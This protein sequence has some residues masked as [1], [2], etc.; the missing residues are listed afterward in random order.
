M[1]IAIFQIDPYSQQNHQPGTKQKF[2]SRSKLFENFVQFWGVRQ[3]GQKQAENQISDEY[4]L[5][6]DFYSSLRRAEILQMCQGGSGRFS[7]WY[8]RHTCFIHMEP[9][10]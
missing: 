6:F 2:L 8:T 3:L 1:Q 7:K 9:K 10:I 5:T 4:L